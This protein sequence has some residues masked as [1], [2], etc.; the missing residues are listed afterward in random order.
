MA[1]RHARHQRGRTESRVVRSFFGT[2]SPER[3]RG[4]RLPIWTE[5]A[6]RERG[7]VSQKQAFLRVGLDRVRKKEKY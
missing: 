7:P 4:L 6:R 5:G 3:E 1:G 2:G